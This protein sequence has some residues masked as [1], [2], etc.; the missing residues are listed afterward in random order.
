MNSNNPLGAGLDEFDNLSELGNT[1]EI[2]QRA[3]K[4]AQLQASKLLTEISERATTVLYRPEID[5]DVCHDVAYTLDRK[6]YL[7]R[8]ND[9]DNSRVR[10][11]LPP[12]R[13]V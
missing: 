6:G 10:G 9:P 5:I 7:P 8:S 3:C 2:E 13:F 11:L 1:F 4:H 12:K